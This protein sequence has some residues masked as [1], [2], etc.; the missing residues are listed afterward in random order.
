MATQAASKRVL[1]GNILFATDFS[2]RS[3]EALP[4]LLSVA[5]KY[6]STISAVH[7]IPR[8]GLPQTM[9]VQA[10]AAQAL[11][12]ADEGMKTVNSRLEGIPHE[13][14]IRKG[15]IGDELSAIVEQ[16]GIDLIAVGTHGRT[17]ASK[18]LMGSVAER[19]VRQASCPVLTVGPNVAGEP[20][21]VA[22]IHT[23]LYPTDF[24]TEAM[25]A[26]PYAVSLA[27]ENQARLYLLHVVPASEADLF[28]DSLRN[29]L[30]AQVPPEAK[31]WCE[32]KAYVESGDAAEK[33]L[34]LAEELGIDLIVLGT[35][36]VSR[37]ASTRTHLGMATAYKIISQAL[38]P[39]L[40]VRG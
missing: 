19:I 32:P 27:Q 33:I 21:S 13:I 25:A 15:D 35:K 40:S 7:V 30:L 28:E 24:S 37:F 17:G 4:F 12:D 39:V 14:V 1:F 20:G 16:K 8:S 34:A 36:H 6:G 10:M 2:K 23:I 18:L 9:E 31:L 22:D 5:H 26:L 38:C 11:R 29:R 3:N